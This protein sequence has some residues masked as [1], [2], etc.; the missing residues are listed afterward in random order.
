MAVVAGIR[1]RK[2]GKV[3][4]FDPTDT[5]P[6]PGDPV[7]VETVRGIELGETVTGSR[8]IPDEK[9]IA[10]LKKIIRI[11]TPEDVRRGEECAAK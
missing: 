6:K 8:E 5:W 10:P 7:V 4:Y 9:L 1:F 11:A 2:A 3:Y